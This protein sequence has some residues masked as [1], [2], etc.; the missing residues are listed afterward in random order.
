MAS[1]DRGDQRLLVLT[2]RLPFTF[3]RTRDGLERRHAAGGLATAL[4]PLMRR[5]GG[6]WLGWPGIDLRP[7]ER[8]DLRDTPYEIAPITLTPNEFDRYYH[9][10]SNR[11]LWPLFHTF[12]S[13]TRF[14]RRDWPV[15]RQVNRRFATLALR[16]MR[17][18]DL[19][20]VHDYHL[21]LTPG[22]LRRSLSDARIAFFLHIP[23]PH[24][25]VFR[26]VPWTREL[27]RGL[28]ACN[29]VGFHVESYARNFL[30]CV[31]RLVDAEVDWK[32]WRI[33]SASGVTQVGAF[34]IGIDFESFDA[35]V[36]GTTRSET[37]RERIVV[38]ADRLDYTKGIPERIIAFERLLEKHPEY[39]EQVVLLQVAV[40]SRHQVAEYRALKREIEELVGRVNG[41]FGTPRWTP[42]RYLYRLLDHDRLAQLYRDAD[43]GLVT[44]LRDGM[45]LVAKEFVTCQTEDDPGVLVLSRLAGAA[46]TMREAL[47]VNP[48]HFERTADQLHRALQ[49]PAEE[50]RL[51]M[52]ALR[53]RER[54]N[55]VHAWVASFLEAAGDGP[56]GP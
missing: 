50:R 23:F 24:F 18:N 54:K 41:R 31:E 40:P 29:L 4:D 5:K 22:Y 43:V 53:N 51:R 33:R 7:G 27:L 46:E 15:Y 37:K 6:T 17:E 48:Y 3:H 32:T 1:Q 12:P 21:M 35:R 30:D 55:D 10:L 44:P 39:R 13:R 28:L 49:M 2:N 45:N 16:S 42:I 36:R 9:G 52:K 56:G 47:L 38:G 14:N 25:D 8:L 11:S 19:V 34:P 26:L 20:W